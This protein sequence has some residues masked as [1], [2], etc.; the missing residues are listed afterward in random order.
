MYANA[1][2]LTIKGKGLNKHQVCY[3]WALVGRYT[4]TFSDL[5]H[6]IVFFLLQSRLLPIGPYVLSATFLSNVFIVCKL[7]LVM[8]IANILCSLDVR[9]SVTYCMI[10]F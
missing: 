3:K 7:T 2:L 8:N 4:A 10:V 6:Y 5:I 9:Q 1:T